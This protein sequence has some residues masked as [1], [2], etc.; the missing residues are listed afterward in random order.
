MIL[1][2]LLVACE[3]PAA[4]RRQGPADPHEATLEKT[5]RYYYQLLNKVRSTGDASLLDQITDP[6]GLDRLNIREFVAE[7]SHKHKLSVITQDRFSLWR[8]VIGIDHATVS[9]DHQ[10]SGY[11]IDAATRQPLEAQTTLKP[12]RIVMELRRHGDVW[13]VFSRQVT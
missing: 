10:I 2:V 13:L 8:F 6:D 9:F 5:I 12:E 1:F 7:Q 11:D 3:V 4:Q